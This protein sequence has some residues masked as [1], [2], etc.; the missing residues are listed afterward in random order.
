[1]RYSQNVVSY[2]ELSEDRFAVRKKRVMMMRRRCIHHNPQPTSGGFSY[3]PH[4]PL[5]LPHPLAGLSNGGLGGHHH[6]HQ[7]S[8]AY[9]DG[10]GRF[11]RRGGV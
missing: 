7:Q 2:E 10:W 3:S 1:L 8:W 6:H 9:V 11:G 4:F 5:P